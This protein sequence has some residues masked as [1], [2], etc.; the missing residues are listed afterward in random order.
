VVF[1]V[2]FLFRRISTDP[3][4]GLITG[5]FFIALQIPELWTIYANMLSSAINDSNAAPLMPMIY[6]RYSDSSPAPEHDGYVETRQDELKR[7]AIS[8]G[9]AL[10][11]A[12]GEQWPTA[13]EI[14]DNILVT[15]KTYPRFGAT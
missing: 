11:Y 15:L 4:T 1:E 5:T 8:C 9:D 13:E 3:L 10:P 7:L 12:E 2:S 14:V 6:H